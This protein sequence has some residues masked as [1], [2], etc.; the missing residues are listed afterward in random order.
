MYMYRFQRISPRKLNVE[1]Y[2]VYPD[3]GPYCVNWIP[4]RKTDIPKVRQDAASK[5]LYEMR[6]STI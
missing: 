2:A 1:V 3:S 6:D 4:C 5:G